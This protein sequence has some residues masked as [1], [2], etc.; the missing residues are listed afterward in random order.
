MILGLLM[1]V[2]LFA[3]GVN[4]HGTVPREFVFPETKA[5]GLVKS[6]Q[7]IFRILGTSVDLMPNTSMI[8]GLQ[9]VRGLDF[10][11]RFTSQSSPLGVLPRNIFSLR[12]A[13][14]VP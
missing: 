8:Y 6:D 4:Y 1:L 11:P 13:W 2:D 3:L 5:L 14:S 12:V 10:P 9:D 7:D